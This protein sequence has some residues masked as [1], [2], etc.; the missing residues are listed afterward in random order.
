MAFV[1]HIAEPESQA[2]VSVALL[3]MGYIRLT[4]GSGFAV[5]LRAEGAQSVHAA[6][7]AALEVLR[8]RAVAQLGRI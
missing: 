2:Q 3:E 8:A 4:V 7:G 5:D 1:V 6:L